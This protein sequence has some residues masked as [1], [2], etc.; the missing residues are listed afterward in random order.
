[1]YSPQW[2]AYLVQTL[3]KWVDTGDTGQ[4][5]VTL[6]FVGNGVKG[7]CLCQWLDWVS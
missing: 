6:F 5:E 2:K 7:S 4:E 3:Q 1:M